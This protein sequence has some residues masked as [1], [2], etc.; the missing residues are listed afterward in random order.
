MN[1]L[2]ESNVAETTFN[3]LSSLVSKLQ[4]ARFNKNEH[5][6]KTYADAL[7]ITIDML[8][9]INVASKKYLEGINHVLKCLEDEEMNLK[10]ILGTT[11]D[12]RSYRNWLISYEKIFKCYKDLSFDKDKM[13]EKLDYIFNDAKQMYFRGVRDKSTF[14]TLDDIENIFIVVYNRKVQNDI[15]NSTEN[16]STSLFIQLLKNR[17]KIEKLS[18]E[19]KTHLIEE[20]VGKYLLN[21]TI[22]LIDLL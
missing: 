18:N 4:Y 20:A 14:L 1:K 6:Y 9:K 3:E 8:Q 5:E 11:K 13:K 15:L 7:K 10:V 16:Y 21:K 12:A 22:H 19:E 2:H 17:I